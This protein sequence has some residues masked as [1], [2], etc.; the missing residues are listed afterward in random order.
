M[1]DNLKNKNILIF[2]NT[3]FVGSWLSI[4]LKIFNANVLGISLKMEN[5]K[6][7]SN[8]TE[9]KKNIQTVYCDI[10][11]LKKIK[12]KIDNFKPNVVIHL[13][14]QPIV[15]HGYKNPF[16]TFNANIMGTVNIFEHIRKIKSVNKI[17][18]FTSDKVYKNNYSTLKEHSC[19]GGQDPYSASKSCQ[20]IIAQSYGYSFFNKNIFILRSGNII[21]GNDW[22]ENRLLPDVINSI[23]EKKALKIR[24]MNSTRPWIHIL[25]VINGILSIINHK[26]INSSFEIYNLA[27][28]I[29]KQISVKQILKVILK[30][31]HAKK[32]NIKEIRNNIIEKKYLR[33]SS[34]KIQKNLKWISRINIE[35]GINLSL[36]IYFSKKQDLYKKTKNQ[37]IKY[38]DL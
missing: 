10:N 21:G 38:F 26:K 7:I 6:Y 29:K 9:F 27:P 24:S 3:G 34:I 14:S 13:A 25:D 20:D 37:I 8:T 17:I 18:I 23:Q 4:A 15:S 1:F 5:S 28:S 22:G 2:G 36:E 31:Q 33:I 30:S 35:K 11:N 19:L 16:K 12:R 32:L